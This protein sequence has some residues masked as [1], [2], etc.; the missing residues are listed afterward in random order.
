MKTIR[1]IIEE[2][3]KALTEN[4]ELVKSRTKEDN[5]KGREV[6][7]YNAGDYLN[8]VE[9]VDASKSYYEANIVNML[10]GNINLKAKRKKVV[11]PHWKY[12]FSDETKM[13]I[14]SLEVE[15]IS[16]ILNLDMTVAEAKEAISKNTAEA[17][18]R[19]N[20]C[21]DDKLDSIIALSEKVNGSDLLDAL[22]AF[23][24]MGYDEQQRVRHE[25]EGKHL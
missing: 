7:L 16:P 6:S 2:A 5:D 11:L 17:T 1:Q 25:L 8:K 19:E 23:K 24:N 15:F 21:K 9:R 12:S 13:I 20:K 14:S 10:S 3:N 4:V 22:Q 18:A